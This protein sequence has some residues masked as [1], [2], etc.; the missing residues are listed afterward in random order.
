MKFAVRTR[1]AAAPPGRAR[2]RPRRPAYSQPA[3]P[4]CGP[5]TSPSSTTSTWTGPP[6]RRWSTPASS[7]WSTPAPMISG[8]YP[9]LGPER[10]GRGR[11]RCVVDDV[12]PEVLDRISDGDRDA[13]RRRVVYVGD[14]ADRARPASSTARSSRP[15]WSRPAPA[16]P[17]S[18]RAS[19]TTAPSSSAAS[20]TCCCTARRAADWRPIAGRPVVVVVAGHELGDELRGIKPLPA[21]AAPGPDRGRPR[22]RRARRRGPQA[23]RR[24]GR[25]AAS[26]DLPGRGRAAQ[27]PATWS[28]SSS[29]AAPRS[30]TERSSGS[31]SAR[32]ASRPA[33]R[34]RTPRCCSPRRRGA[35][36][37]IGVGMHATLDEF[38]D[39]QRTG[40]A[41]TYLTR[42]KVG[43]E[44]VDAAALPA[45]VRRPVRPRHLLGC[46]CSPAC[47][48]WLPPSASPPSARSGSTTSPGACPSDLIDNVQGMLP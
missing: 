31:A 22:R 44:L 18:W 28:C 25:P 45:A 39:R 19:P 2:H 9:N 20:R 24:G 41:S 42:L 37:I 40:L 33:P 12:G 38:L 14:D 47:S 4:G 27:A 29:G 6:P 7:P 43:P 1:P 13:H 15:R 5:A 35:A 11:R 48:P 10:A 36:L 17:P 16:W 23:R 26:D 30:A 46:R 8:R 3:A 34:P 21:R 32:C